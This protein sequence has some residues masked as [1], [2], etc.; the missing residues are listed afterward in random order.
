MRGIAKLTESKFGA[1]V[2]GRLQRR[3]PRPGDTWHL[4]EVFI[5]IRGVQHYLWRRRSAFCRRQAE[6]WPPCVRAVAARI[7]SSNKKIGTRARHGQ[8]LV[9]GR[10]AD[11]L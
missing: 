1:E 5:R 7:G 10:L 2:A 6:A 4:D 8:R 3:R 11:G 9:T